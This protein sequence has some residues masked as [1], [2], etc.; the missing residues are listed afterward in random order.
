[1]ETEPTVELLNVDLELFGLV[2]S[3]PL[4]RC[5]GDAVLVIADEH[6]LSLELSDS[7]DSTLTTKLA[8][9]VALV[10]ALPEDA[11]GAWNSAS[12]RVFNIGIQSGLRPSCTEWAIP[13]SIL[14][15][16]VEIR[17]EVTLT[18]YGAEYAQEKLS[19]R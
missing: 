6:L 17:A 14:A 3:E 2:D 12:R 13:T 19:S 1:M 18:I 5:F 16:L 10:I 9:F 4:L 7:P 15:S 11:R 8:E